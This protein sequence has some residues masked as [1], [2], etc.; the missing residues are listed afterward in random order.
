MDHLAHPKYLYRTQFSF[1]IGLIRHR[2][3]VRPSSIRSDQIIVV[4]YHLLISG[5]LAD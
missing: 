4:L 3:G 1:H 5:G 2:Y